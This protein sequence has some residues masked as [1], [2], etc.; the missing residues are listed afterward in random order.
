MI[1]NRDRLPK[2]GGGSGVGGVT[3]YAARDTAD[4]TSDIKVVSG[5][6]APS[7]FYRLLKSGALVVATGEHLDIRLTNPL[8]DDQRQ[9]VKDHKPTLLDLADW[10]QDDADLVRSLTEAEFLPLAQDYLD[11]R[12]HY[13]KTA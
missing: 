10:Y 7:I 1:G 9:A 12:N 3:S 5:G 4:T 2:N 11:H 13:R 6:V 8:T